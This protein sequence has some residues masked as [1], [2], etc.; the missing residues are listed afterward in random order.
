MSNRLA[1]ETSPYLL[2]HKDNPVD[3]YSWGEEALALARAED[4]PILLSIGYSA[5]HWCHVMEHES[6]E[7]PAIA[8]LMNEHFVSI[9]VDREERPDL[10]SLYM[11]AVQ[12][13]TGHGGWPM[14]VFLTPD[15]RPFYGGTYY[16]PEDRGPMPG[17]PR[18][19]TAVAAAYRDKR[20]QLEESAS[21][22]TNHLQQHFEHDPES[23]VLNPSLL[24][25]AA[26]NLA[27]QFDRVN[28]GFGGA[29]KFPSPMA[30][31]LLLRVYA[32]TRAE[33]ALQMAEFTL[34][35]MGRG[36]LYDQIGG[37][38]HRYAVDAIWLV[39]H[40]EKMLYDNA[41][42][43]H[44]YTIAWQL[45]GEPFYRAIADETFAYV[46]A[47]M[48]APGGGFYSTQDADSEGEEGKFYAWTV[49]EL[50]EVLGAED[51]DR[52]A[53]LL[54]VTERGN[55]EGSN[56]LS[57]P[58]VADRMTWRS[59]EIA[60]LRRKLYEARSKRVWPGRD[61]KVL[62]SWNGMMLRAFATAAWVFDDEQYAEVGRSNARF[63]REH[64]YRDG[65]LLRTWKDG[66]AKLNGYLEDYANF[67]DGLLA[68][69]GATFEIEW[70]RFATELART[71]LGEFYQD[72][73]F[74]DTG[75]T[76]EALV[77][78]PR[79]AYDSATPSGNSVACDVLL[80]LA[81]L[82]GD[83][84]FSQVATDVL[85]GFGR[86]ASESAHG[87]ARLLSAVD[88]AVGP[89][90]EVAV[91]GDPA[92]GDTQ[93]LLDTLR[94]EFLPRSVVAVVAPSELEEQAA[95]I[96]L[97]AGREQQGGQATAYVCLN[98]ACQL[99]TIEPEVMLEQLQAV[100][101]SG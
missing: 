6:F 100:M 84:S 26:R 35:K 65:K 8:A 98:Y 39:P 16:P 96:P 57:I 80:R 41:Q 64:L 94:D 31:E 15:G 12:M 33:R 58:N 97:F 9:K 5:C 22:I 72:G 79:D 93:A 49:A 13:M 101:S 86:A 71:M 27:G 53:G 50:R 48:T 55:F 54:G 90:A 11:M 74:Y 2:Q 88:V 36:G 56:V 45:T 10:D 61:E 81:H 18:I 99:P 25:E 60:P 32:R 82:T 17:F 34:D 91:V 92:A 3:W 46:L 59:E 44:V 14:T 43:A 37:G 76:H 19:L 78:R 75:V 29:P 73:R 69:Y 83:T 66:R 67:I 87:Y 40:F 77:T 51:G 62:T 47:E 4:R 23:G 52:V 7:N 30:V 24:D 38:F 70:L 95:F 85:G 68:L 28:G 1:N 89:S 21:N 42:L 63:V 20:D